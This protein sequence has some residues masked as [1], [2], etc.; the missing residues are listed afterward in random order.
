MTS[1]IVFSW[2]IRFLNLKFRNTKY[3]ANFCIYSELCC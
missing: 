2:S 1:S 3:R